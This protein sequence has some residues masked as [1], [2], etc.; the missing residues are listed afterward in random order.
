MN[1]IERF[2]AVLA[3]EKPDRLPL[4]IPTIACP[5][6]LHRIGASHHSFFHLRAGRIPRH[7]VEGS[8]QSLALASCIGGRETSYRKT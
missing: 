8:L 2:H 1:S 3:H 7:S 4:Y 5:V 6:S